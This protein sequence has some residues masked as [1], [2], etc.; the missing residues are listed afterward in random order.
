MISNKKRIRVDYAPLSLAVSVEC[1]TP[2]SPAMQV[3]N[4]VTGEYEPNRRLSPST[5]WPMIMANANDGSWHN[6]YANSVLTDMKWFVD[7]VE[8]SQH[9]DWSGALPDGRAKYVI[10]STDSN[11]RGAITINENVSPEKQYSLHFEGK[12]TDP[13]LGAVLDVKSDAFVLSTQDVVE[14][15]R[16]LSIGEDQ[17]IQYNP[18][19]DKLHLYDYK[20]AHGLI[21]A[22]SAAEAA[23][24]DENAY[25]REIPISLFSGPNRMTTGYSI[26]LYRVTGVNTFTK[27][28]AGAEEVVAITPTAITL[29][30]RVVT[31][32]DYLIKAIVSD[33][34]RVAPQLQFSVNRVYQ[35]FNCRPTNGTSI[36]PGDVQR[37]D[38][39]MVD[40]DGNIVECPENIIRI[41]W[42]TDTATITGQ[43]HNEGEITLFSL[44]KTGIG[45]NYN[46]DWLDIYTEVEI[47]AQHDFAIDES[48]NQFVDENGNKLIFN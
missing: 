5:F 38:K 10:D 39:A 11:Y 46:D 1:I 20:V 8:I 13:R 35:E 47:K 3:Y 34:V 15:M 22:G 23:A 26:E 17:I 45:I 37:F 19:K 7:D 43:V 12:V 6:Q 21:S 29:D 36:N 30:L 33:T 32:A 9:P 16:L 44:D 42:K 48:G 31:K 4:T 14:D 18:F 24:K 25:L 2:G 40:S 28:T 27:L 41:V